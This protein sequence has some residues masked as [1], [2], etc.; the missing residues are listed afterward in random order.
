MCVRER[1]K[2]RERE[3]ER[4]RKRE[5]ARESLDPSE[6]SFTIPCESLI[7]ENHS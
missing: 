3:R 2:E 6:Q 4:E 5:H 7:N 1:E